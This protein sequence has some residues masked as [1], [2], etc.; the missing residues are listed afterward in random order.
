[1]PEQTFADQTL[2]VAQVSGALPRP[3]N[4]ATR[5]KLL[6]ELPFFEAADLYVWL[7]LVQLTYV[8]YISS[9]RLCCVLQE[10]GCFFK[11]QT[12][13]VLA[14]YRTGNSIYCQLWHRVR[15]GT[16]PCTHSQLHPSGV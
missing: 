16:E 6:L 13:P 11:H 12:Q 15:V 3:A 9:L 4:A 2:S 10:Q 8:L 1:M 5:C 7:S 14:A